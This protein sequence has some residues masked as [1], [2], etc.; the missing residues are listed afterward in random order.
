MTDTDTMPSPDDF[1]DWDDVDSTTVD[2][3]PETYQY[4][5]DNLDEETGCE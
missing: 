3:G 5:G 2:L 4:P 1:D